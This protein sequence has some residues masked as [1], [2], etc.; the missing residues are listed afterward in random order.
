MV[1]PD[2]IV[3]GGRF[4]HREGQ[5]AHG[6]VLQG[7]REVAQRPHLA[8]GANGV[9]EN[10]AQQRR[11]SAQFHVCDGRQAHRS[12]IVVHAEEVRLR[13]Q[14][15]IAF[16]H[17]VH[18]E[19]SAWGKGIALQ[20]GGPHNRA[21]RRRRGRSRFSRRRRGRSRFSRRRR[22]R[23]R[24]GR[25]RRDRSR[26]GRRRRDRGRF[27]R[28]RRGRGRFGR[29]RRRHGA[30]QV[31]GSAVVE[32]DE[33]FVESRVHNRHVGGIVVQPDRVVLGRRFRHREGQTAHGQVQLGVRKI[34]QRAHLAEGPQ[35]IFENSAQQRGLSA[36]FHVGDARQA[37]RGGIVVH[38]EKI[39][40]G[41]QAGVPA[42]GDIHRKRFSGSERIARR[43]GGCDNRLAQRMLSSQHCRHYQKKPPR[44]DLHKMLSLP[45]CWYLRFPTA[46]R[47]IPRKSPGFALCSPATLDTGLKTPPHYGHSI[48]Y[49][50]D[51]ARTED[52]RNVF[53][54]VSR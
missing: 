16:Q 7:V 37:H 14:A 54:A 4:R 30:A 11:L 9:F 40:L 38:T 33:D 21:K 45:S 34:A 48:P 24:F 53:F 10:C 1:Q 19:G 8:E 28:R 25:R 35:F 41:G 18:R 2:R 50:G 51:H 27:G 31:H 3:L 36:Q 20:V 47:S 43:T 44:V 5:T 17:H 23:S 46:D 6:Q 42:Q 52:G 15:R 22:D 32:V 39:R 26:F 29:R 49:D 13:G 12:G